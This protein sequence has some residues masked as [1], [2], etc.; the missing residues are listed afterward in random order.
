MMSSL[1][2]ACGC[3]GCSE[4]PCG[5][6][7]SVCS[8]VAEAPTDSSDSIRNESA[9][10]SSEP[11]PSRSDSALSWQELL[12]R[13]Q[14]LRLSISTQLSHLQPYLHRLIPLYAA[15]LFLRTRGFVLLSGAALGF[16]YVAYPAG[17]PQHW[18]AQFCVLV[19]QVEEERDA[20]A[21]AAAAAA[22]A[23]AAAPSLTDVLRTVQVSSRQKKTCIFLRVIRHCQSPSPEDPSPAALLSSCSV[24]VTL[25][26]QW[27][28][29]KGR[30]ATAKQQ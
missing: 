26:R 8:A 13:R 7:C 30:Q 17:G 16:D 10:A 23:S 6:P 18:H 4:C 3:L 29:A 28:A 9:A 22:A 1:S 2:C 27:A 19:G 14:Y 21:E 20:I 12:F 15:Y 11:A 25:L 5:R 24:S